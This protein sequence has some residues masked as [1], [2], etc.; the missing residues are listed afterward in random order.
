MSQT[1]HTTNKNR[2]MITLGNCTIE[3]GK[4]LK[5]K[6]KVMLKHSFQNV[7]NSLLQECAV[8]RTM[9]TFIKNLKNKQR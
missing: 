3:R 7:S 9:I 2:E 6:Q 4:Q 8:K 5:E 1:R